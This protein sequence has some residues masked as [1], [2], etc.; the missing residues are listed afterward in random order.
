[1]TKLFK[2]A[3]FNPISDIWKKTT[4]EFKTIH[5]P[6]LAA[7]QYVRKRGTETNWKKVVQTVEIE[8]AV[9]FFK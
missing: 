3:V 5:S 8:L 4:K 9:I 6:Y 7:P 2:D 1:M